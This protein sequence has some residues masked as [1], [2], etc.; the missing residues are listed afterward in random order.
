MRQILIRW[1]P[2]PHHRQP[3]DWP[4][5]GLALFIAFVAAAGATWLG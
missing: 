2:H 3:I 4:A 5:L 1:Q